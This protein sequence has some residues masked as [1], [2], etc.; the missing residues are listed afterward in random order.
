MITP[1]TINIRVIG[2]EVTV[3]YNL[4]VE[5]KKGLCHH[6]GN[7]ANHKH[8]IDVVSV[9]EDTVE[10]DKESVLFVAAAKNTK[11]KLGDGQGLCGR[12]YCENK[13][14]EEYAATA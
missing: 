5:Q 13:H 7:K 14:A 3:F 2:R 6:C 11:A 1:E 9:C 12:R 4:N 10:V 8:S